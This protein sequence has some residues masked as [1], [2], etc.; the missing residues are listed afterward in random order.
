M[1]R[2][3]TAVRALERTKDVSLNANNRL[4]LVVWIWCRELEPE[5]EPELTSLTCRRLAFRGFPNGL[6][7][8]FFNASIVAQSNSNKEHITQCGGADTETPTERTRTATT[9]NHKPKRRRLKRTKDE[10]EVCIKSM[11]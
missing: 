9:G 7:G 2:I 8:K 11:E 10:D 3:A 4:T 6:T 1:I 5:L